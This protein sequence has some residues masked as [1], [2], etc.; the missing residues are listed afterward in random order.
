MP[1]CQLHIMTNYAIDKRGMERYE[2]SPPFTAPTN[3]R[4]DAGTGRF[5][6]GVPESRSI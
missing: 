6:G 4:V 5:G 3:N 2:R 1:A